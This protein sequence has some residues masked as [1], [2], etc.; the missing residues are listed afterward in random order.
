MIVQKIRDSAILKFLIFYTIYSLITL[1]F[2]LFS[3]NKLAQNVD[4]L[5]NYNPNL[6]IPHD[7]QVCANFGI[8]SLFLVAIW[9]IVLIG[10]LLKAMF[11][12]KKAL[13][14]SF[15]IDEI[16]DLG[17]MIADIRNGVAK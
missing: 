15:C 17:K 5:R 2:V 9:V 1:A 7:L 14:S 13:K 6:P 8:V 16:Q 12:N 4:L 3:I 10:L 11:P